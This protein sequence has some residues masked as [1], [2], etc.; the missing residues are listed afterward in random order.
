[1]IRPSLKKASKSSPNIIPRETFQHISG[2]HH[3]FL[4]IL[5]S[6]TFSFIL[7]GRVAAGAVAEKYLSE[8]FGIEIVAF[9]S[10]VGKV[11]IPRFVGERLATSSSATN[12]IQ[13][14][15]AAPASSVDN[16]ISENITEEEADEPLSKE[17]RKLLNEVTRD[18]VDRND[19]RCPHEEAAERMRD[20][21]FVI[22]KH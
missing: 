18:M 9:V 20:V 3:L 5:L 12:G 8:A 15:A 1:M 6:S 21:S 11:H 22:W 13:D 10:S 17:F 4:T 7:P 19:I 14:A 16:Y 2:S